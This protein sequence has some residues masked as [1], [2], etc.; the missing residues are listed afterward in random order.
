L[1]AQA[2]FATFVDR[3]C[4]AVAKIQQLKES[5]QVMVAVISTT[6]DM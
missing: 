6:G 3:E 4:Q 5:L 1:R 2:D